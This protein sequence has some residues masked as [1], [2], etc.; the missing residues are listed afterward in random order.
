MNI[1]VKRSR[2]VTSEHFVCI[3][4][5]VIYNGFIKDWFN[6]VTSDQFDCNFVTRFDVRKGICK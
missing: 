1:A 6:K 4:V 3:F 5:I 2:K